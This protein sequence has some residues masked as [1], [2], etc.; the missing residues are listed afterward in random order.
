MTPRLLPMA[1]LAAAMPGE[2]STAAWATGDEVSGASGLSLGRARGLCTEA[3]H[4][5]PVRR[6]THASPPA[7]GLQH[8][9]EAATW[10]RATLIV[11]TLATIRPPVPSP[12]VDSADHP[13]VGA[14]CGLC[15]PGQHRVLAGS[16]G[17][18][19]DEPTLRQLTGHPMALNSVV[20]RVHGCHA[21]PQVD[22]DS[23]DHCVDSTDQRDPRIR[24]LPGYPV[25]SAGIVQVIFQ[26]VF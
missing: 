18:L 6:R 11:W 21:D 26:L 5:Q 2:Q 19:H 14:R 12:P 10:S 20:G 24:D 3:D 16:S 25:D 22:V 15:R 7:Q 4:V 17:R 1:V 8:Q 23:A 9:V 13:R